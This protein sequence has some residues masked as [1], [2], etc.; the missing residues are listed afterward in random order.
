MSVRNS[1]GPSHIINAASKAAV[2]AEAGE[3]KKDLRHNENVAAAGEIFYPLIVE[4]HEVWSMHILKVLKSFA[5]KTSLFNGLTFSRT[6][7]NLHEQLLCKLW[8]YNAK[9]IVNK[10]ALFSYDMDS[11]NIVSKILIYIYIY[12]VATTNRQITVHE[13]AWKLGPE[14]SQMI[15]TSFN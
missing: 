13:I 4:T 6:L 3:C 5:K 9:L 1:F 7:C 14:T 8:Q 11:F 12:I 15:E 2:A 10:L